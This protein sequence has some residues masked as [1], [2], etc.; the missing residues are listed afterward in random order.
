[1]NPETLNRELARFW[2]AVVVSLCIGAGVGHFFY[3]FL[4][5][6]N[7]K[8]VVVEDCRQKSYGQRVVR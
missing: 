4:G 2:L 1:M 7:L 3:G 8:G 5:K 6:A